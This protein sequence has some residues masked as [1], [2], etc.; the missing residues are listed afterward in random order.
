MGR[1]FAAQPGWLALAAGRT[2]S[3]FLRPVSAASIALMESSVVRMA[4]PQ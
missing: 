1:R 2:R 3:Y 4:R